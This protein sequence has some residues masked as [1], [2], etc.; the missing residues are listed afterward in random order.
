KTIDDASDFD[1]QPQNPYNLRAERGLSRQDVRNRFV[2]NSLFDVPIGE[3]ENDKGKS[4]TEPNLIGKIFGHIEAAPVFTFSSGRA[5][6]ILT[7]TDEEHSGAYPFASRPVGF[8]R[9]TFLTPRLV[10]VDV[11]IVKYVPYGEQRRL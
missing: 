7:G 4:Q 11:R 8:G 10:N 1:E 3:D 2:V 9:N 6:N 5:A